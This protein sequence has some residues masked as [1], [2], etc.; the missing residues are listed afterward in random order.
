M[1]DT[2]SKYSLSYAPGYCALYPKLAGL[3]KWHGYALAVHG[4]CQRDFDA[5]VKYASTPEEVVSAI[6]K[7]F[8]LKEIGTPTIKEHGRI[9]YTLP[10]GFGECA[11]DLSFM[12]LVE[13]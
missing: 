5:W 1:T 4:S 11:V 9:A 3:A 8:D 12:P 13:T 6:T 7:A 2:K 10:I